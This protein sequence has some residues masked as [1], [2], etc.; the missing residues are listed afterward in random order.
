M[1]KQDFSEHI[2]DQLYAHEHRL[3]AK[4]D[5][6]RAIR[7]ALYHNVAGAFEINELKGRVNRHRLQRAFSGNPFRVPET[8][9][10]DLCLG[11]D[12]QGHP[13][14]THAQ[15]LNAHVL[16]LGSSGS[17]KTSFAQQLILR[18]ARPGLG[19]WMFDLRKREFAKLRKPLAQLGID[20][21]VLPGRRIRINPLQIPEQ[22]TPQNYA[23]KVAEML[24]QVLRLPPRASKLLH[25]TL[26]K[27]YQAHGNGGDMTNFPTLF[28]LYRA[29]EKQKK[30]NHPARLAVLDSLLPLLL[31]LGPEV[32]GWSVGW[33]TSDLARL[34]IVFDFS[35]LSETEKDLILNTLLLSEF[36]SRI[37]R[38][39]SNRTMDLFLIC[40]EAARLCSTSNTGYGVDDQI[41][42]IRGT[43][44]GLFLLLQTADISQTILSN[45]ATKI[46]ARCGSARDYRVM[47]DAMGL[48]AEHLQW[49]AL[50][51]APGK[52][53]VQLGEGRWRHPFVLTIPHVTF[54]STRNMDTDADALGALAQLPSI[55]SA[56]MLEDSLTISGEDTEPDDGKPDTQL[57]EAELRYLDAVLAHPALPS[58]KYASLAGVGQSRARK[59]R[60]GLIDKG[61][62]REWQVNAKGRGRSS[63]LLEPLEPALQLSGKNAEPSRGDAS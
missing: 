56:T 4:D 36:S 28:D 54:P 49:M 47:G 46:V 6:G 63:L 45:T 38:G 22:D 60:Q 30:S 50:N 57:S 39:V 58:S 12:T 17:T 51:L 42:L 53:V 26:L 15:Y 13:I 33:K 27:L 7:E 11:N 9:K 43:G 44:I 20:L 21:I 41:G 19:L 32:L 3:L 62:L 29:I 31:G 2:R 35:G 10:G 37:A 25:V 59:I 34:A 5:V 16:M 8:G 14:Y 23:P 61:Y 48:N 55:P 40:D 1:N 18:M 24:V 52:F